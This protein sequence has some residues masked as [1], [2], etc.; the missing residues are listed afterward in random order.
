MGE[1]EGR[2]VFERWV[3]KEAELRTEMEAA[4]LGASSGVMWSWLLVEKK[5]GKTAASFGRNM[6]KRVF[7][8]RGRALCKRKA[9]AIRVG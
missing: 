2:S 7:G 6:R 1:L 8:G 4:G 9:V 5:R 3:G